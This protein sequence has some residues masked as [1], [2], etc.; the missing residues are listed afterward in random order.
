MK[1]LIVGAVLLFLLACSKAPQPITAQAAQVVIKCGASKE[2]GETCMD[3]CECLKPGKCISGVCAL[4]GLAEG[5]ACFTDR[6][7]STGSCIKNTCKIPGALSD[8]ISCELDCTDRYDDSER[9][10]TVCRR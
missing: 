7:C 6:Q 1:R 5:Q 2:I 10:K 8:N 9:C 3:A 4:V